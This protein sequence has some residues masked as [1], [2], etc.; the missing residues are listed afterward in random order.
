M[1]SLMLK[2]LV[3]MTFTT[4]LGCAPV[5]VKI[6]ISAANDLPKD[7][8][9]KYLNKIVVEYKSREHRYHGHM[10]IFEENE[11]F[12]SFGRSRYE[13]TYLTVESRWDR[14]SFEADVEFKGSLEGCYLTHIKRG[15]SK[16]PTDEQMKMF[17]KIA[18]ALKSL[19]VKVEQNK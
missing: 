6:D 9:I 4:L 2:I 15:K 1:K 11:V 16:K 7:I 18:T 3:G 14:N 5:P 13:Q 8:A 12:N 19:G 17:T 10:C